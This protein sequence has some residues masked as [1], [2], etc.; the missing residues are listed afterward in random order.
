M[1]FYDFDT[2]MDTFIFYLELGISHVLDPSA[3]DHVLFLAALAIPF[4]LSHRLRVVWLA[5][6][7]TLTHC[8]ALALSVYQIVEVNT[9]WIE[10]L[11]PLSILGMLGFN[12]AQAKKETPQG[13]WTLHL[14]ATLLFGLIHGFGFSNYFK[15]LMGA[16]KSQAGPLVAFAAGLEIAQIT[17]IT[18]VLLLGWSLSQAFK[19]SKSTYIWGGSLLVG[20]LTLPLQW[21]TLLAL[22]GIE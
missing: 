11:I 18:A 16:E 10:F 14:G 7:F 4:S 19:L 15:M 17:V 1:Y 20:L 12:M 22:L 3:Y 9:T 13:N 5:T 8:T 2:L 6:A 21:N